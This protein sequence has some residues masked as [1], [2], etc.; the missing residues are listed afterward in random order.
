M[1]RDR[2]ETP[3]WRPS[4]S[5][6]CTSG[7]LG[8]ARPIRFLPAPGPGKPETSPSGSNALPKYVASTS[9][10]V[11]DRKPAEL[12]KG[13]LPEAVRKLKQGSG[14]SDIYVHGGLSVAQ[15]LLRHGLVDR[16]RLLSYPGAVDLGQAAAPARR[17]GAARADF[18]HAIRQPLRCLDR[19]AAVQLEQCGGR[20]AEGLRASSAPLPPPPLDGS[21][22]R[23][24][25][26]LSTCHFSSSLIS[27]SRAPRSS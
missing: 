19:F 3:L 15:E 1:L 8:D 9:L 12:L 26:T 2:L 24:F 16:V 23:A 4:D 5:V 17:A 20:R 25:I 27:P 10:R 14:G 7:A 22:I 21:A 6:F 11:L 13:A 18:G